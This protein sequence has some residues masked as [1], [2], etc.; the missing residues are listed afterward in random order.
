MAF[1]ACRFEKSRSQG[2]GLDYLGRL[3]LPTYHP[4]ATIVTAEGVISVL[5]LPLT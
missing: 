2:S 5:D 1:N 3:K 4:P